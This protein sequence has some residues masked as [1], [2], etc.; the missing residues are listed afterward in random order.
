MI[1]VKGDVVIVVKGGDVC[2]WL[3]MVSVVKGGCCD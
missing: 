2:G 1:V 3:W